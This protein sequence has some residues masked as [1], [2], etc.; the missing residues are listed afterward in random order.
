MEKEKGVHEKKPQEIMARTS[1]GPYP[2]G[3]KTIRK[4]GLFLLPSL[5]IGHLMLLPS[6]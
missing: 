2:K 5:P 6:V 4:D 1:R 3:K